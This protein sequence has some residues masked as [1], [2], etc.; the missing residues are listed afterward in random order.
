MYREEWDFGQDGRL[1]ARVTK[2]VTDPAAS[3]RRLRTCLSPR[4]F[5]SHI[6]F[7]F[8]KKGCSHFWQESLSN[9]CGACGGGR[10]SRGQGGCAPAVAFGNP[11]SGV[12]P[13]G[14]AFKKSSTC[15]GYGHIRYYVCV[16][17]HLYNFSNVCRIGQ[18]SI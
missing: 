16:W 3:P 6:C 7:M 4:V 9:H 17:S 11:H 12:G 1:I 15:Y 5:V 18:F 13:V 10:R 14:V 8:Q 2:D